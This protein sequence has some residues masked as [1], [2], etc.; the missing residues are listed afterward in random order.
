MLLDRLP[1]NPDDF[2]NLL[3]LSATRSREEYGLSTTGWVYSV[4]FQNPYSQLYYHMYSIGP[5]TKSCIFMCATPVLEYRAVHPIV[6]GVVLIQDRLSERML[7]KIKNIALDVR[8][9]DKDS[10]S[11]IYSL[12]IKHCV[13]P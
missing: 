13:T 9:K 7:G 2:D 8:G 4:S 5:V 11:R 12:Y 10:R 3:E 1:D 6:G